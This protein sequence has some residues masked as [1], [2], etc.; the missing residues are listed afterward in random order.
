MSKIDE[1]TKGEVQPL[2]F[3][4]RR[5]FKEI[6]CSSLSASAQ[7]L[8]SSVCCLTAEPV[9]IHSWTIGDNLELFQYRVYPS[10]V[11]L[12]K[13][14]KDICD[15]SFRAFKLNHWGKHYAIA[16]WDIERDVV[17]IFDSLGSSREK[18]YTTQQ[19]IMIKKLF[20]HTGEMIPKIIFVNNKNLQQQD[21]FCQTYIYY[22]L[23]VILISCFFYC[24]SDLDYLHFI[25]LAY[26][27]I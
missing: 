17:E 14:S 20:L 7:E 18:D 8:F 21:K 22:Y 19:L 3:I 27:N 1:K 13:S 4:S 10:A 5:S 11:R 2:R 12:V 9:D 24:F 26:H 16:L 23:Y 15:H 6:Q 25:L